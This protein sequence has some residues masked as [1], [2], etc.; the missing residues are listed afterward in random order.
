LKFGADPSYANEFRSC[1]TALKELWQKNPQAIEAVGPFIAESP[2][3]IAI[4]QTKETARNEQAREN[5]EQESAAF[6]LEATQQTSRT[7]KDNPVMAAMRLKQSL[8]EVSA[9]ALATSVDLLGPNSE[10]D[11]ALHMAMRNLKTYEGLVE[12]LVKAKMP[13]NGKDK[14]GVTALMLAAGDAK[15]TTVSTLIKGG[16]ALEIKDRDGATALFFAVL[17]GKKD[18]VQVLLAHGAKTDVKQNDGNTALSL[19]K[20]QGFREIVQ[21][22]ESVK[23]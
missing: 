18:T 6:G 9:L 2:A 12:I 10:G 14:H 20:Q 13:L 5:K 11:T 3:K 17:A 7:L 23:Q 16:A 15:T 19:A 21:I 4:C 8:A 1:K 22:L